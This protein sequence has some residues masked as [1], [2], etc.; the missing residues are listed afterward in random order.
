MV[1]PFLGEIRLFPFDYA[2]QGWA[3]CNG[4]LLQINQNQALFSFIGNTYGGD[5]KT[6]FAVPDLR[7]RV[8][9]PAGLNTKFQ[10]TIK[11]GDKGGSETVAL[12]TAQMP[13]HTHP[14]NANGTNGDIV[15]PVSPT[16]A[17][18]WAEADLPDSSLLNAYSPTANVT[19]DPTIIS[20]KGGGQ[21]HNNMQPFLVL[22]FCIATIGI[23]PLRS[24]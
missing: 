5:G 22:N 19:M 8:P 18:I 9:V 17:F 7:G 23:F 21:G 10:Y 12:T 1:E 24:S 11:P 4:A 2:P 6:T 15:S 14:V 3:L 13:A 16:N 20:T